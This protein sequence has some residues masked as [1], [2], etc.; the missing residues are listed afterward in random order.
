MAV[1]IEDEKA[2]LELQ[3][4]ML[5]STQALSKARACVNSLVFVKICR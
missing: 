4:R 3:D 2:L 1:N 5:D